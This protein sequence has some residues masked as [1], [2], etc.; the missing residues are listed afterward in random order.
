MWS[1]VGLCAMNHH[2]T[3]TVKSFFYALFSA[4]HL[5]G[6]QLGPR[7]GPLMTCGVFP[8]CHVCVHPWILFKDAVSC[9]GY[10]VAVVGE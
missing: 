7:K 5:Y 9:E 3:P 1:T 4:L 6:V 2:S 10:T 8:Q